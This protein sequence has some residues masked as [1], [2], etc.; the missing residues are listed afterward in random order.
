MGVFSQYHFLLLWSHLFR[1]FLLVNCR[2][3]L[4]RSPEHQ[5][6]DEDLPGLEEDMVPGLN[7]A[8]LRHR[9]ITAAAERHLQDPAPWYTDWHWQKSLPCHHLKRHNKY[10]KSSPIWCTVSGHHLFKTIIKTHCKHG[11][12][13][14]LGCL[15]IKMA[16]LWTS[17]A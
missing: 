17:S 6:E 8:V 5:D 12:L 11:L 10:F 7:S 14:V 16:Q 4:N 2:R 9:T 3:Y 15:N 1:W 13:T